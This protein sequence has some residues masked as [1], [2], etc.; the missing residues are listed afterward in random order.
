MRCVFCDVEIGVDEFPA[1]AACGA[2]ENQQNRALAAVVRGVASDPR[3]APRESDRDF[4]EG[5]VAAALEFLAEL[6]PTRAVERM[7]FQSRLAEARAK[8][9]WLDINGPKALVLGAEVVEFD[10]FQAHCA[11]RAGR[12]ADG[13]ME[14]F[15]GGLCEEAGEAYG[16]M[17][18][19]V[20]HGQPLD[21][22]KYLKE[23]G[24]AAWYLAMAA[25]S[26]GASLSDVI[27]AQVRKNYERY[28]R[29]FTVEDAT[30]RAD[31]K[32]G[33]DDL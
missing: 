2:C 9:A 5:E 6:P 26:V 12:H 8:L 24:D 30:R 4:L 10:A 15:P 27:R 25:H 1:G 18:K 22:E 11:A 23:L 20:Y 33:V 13:H 32:K 19:H 3:S 29:G 14:Y 7:G 28:P 31:E 21:R 17:K 16:V